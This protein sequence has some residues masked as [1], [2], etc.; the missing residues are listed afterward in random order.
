MSREF[1]FYSQAVH[2]NK[3]LFENQAE[4]LDKYIMEELASKFKHVLTQL[5]TQ[6]CFISSSGM[7]FILRDDNDKAHSRVIY[8]Q[9]SLHLM[10]PATKVKLK[11]I[12]S[13]H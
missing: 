2:E 8:V 12:L 4:L 6:G 13:H 1:Y 5:I 7:V 3:G 9:T 10:R 11:Q